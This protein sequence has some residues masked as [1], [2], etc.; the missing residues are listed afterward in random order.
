MGTYTFCQLF[1]HLFCKREKKSQERKM[2][3]LSV[4]INDLGHIIRNL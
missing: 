4:F 1:Y 2:F 3:L